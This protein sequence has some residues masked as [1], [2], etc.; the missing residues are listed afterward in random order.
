MRFLS[1]PRPTKNKNYIPAKAEI[2]RKWRHFHQ[3]TFQTQ[4]DRYFCSD[5]GAAKSLAEP[6][7]TKDQQ[8]STKVFVII[9]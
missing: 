4:V 9:S 1:Y 6:G 2:V 8:G 5:V 3:I 7:Y